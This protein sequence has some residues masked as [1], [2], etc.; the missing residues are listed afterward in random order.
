MAYLLSDVSLEDDDALHTLTSC[1]RRPLRICEFAISQHD[2]HQ[3]H[4]LVFLSNKAGGYV[5]V[6]NAFVRTAMGGRLQELSWSKAPDAGD[7]KPEGELHHETWMLVFSFATVP[8][9]EQHLISII[10]VCYG[11]SSRSGGGTCRLQV[12]DELFG[13]SISVQSG[14]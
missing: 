4:E 13:A 1:P 6:M 10:S 12:L 9:I 11:S 3:I 5:A 14:P 2:L 8:E 7:V